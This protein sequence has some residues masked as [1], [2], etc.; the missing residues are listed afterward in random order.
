M[1]EICQGNKMVGIQSIDISNFIIAKDTDNDKLIASII[2]QPWNYSY[3]GNIM[4]GVRL[5]NAF[6]ETEYQNQ[7]I[8]KKILNKIAQLSDAEDCLFE[9]VYGENSLY[10]H[11]GYTCFCQVENQPAF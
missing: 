2:Y 5:E 6:C 3:G 1:I 11:L 7:G 9:L 10:N 8:G 4:K